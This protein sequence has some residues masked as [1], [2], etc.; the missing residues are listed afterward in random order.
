MLAIVSSINPLRV[1]VKGTTTPVPVWRYSS[2]APNLQTGEMVWVEK[3]DR[4]YILQ[5]RLD[6]T[7]S[8]E[9]NSITLLNGWTSWGGGFPSPRWRRLG[10]LV[11]V[12]AF[13]NGVDSTNDHW[14]TIPTEVSPDY[15]LPYILGSK[16]G[17]DGMCRMDVLSSGVC[18]LSIRG[19]SWHGFHRTYTI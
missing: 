2:S 1:V 10:N 8:G 3:V 14:G 9:W 5:S 7:S 16:S 6:S 17:G 13:L 11:E 18:R 12:Q 15:H 4:K 19:T